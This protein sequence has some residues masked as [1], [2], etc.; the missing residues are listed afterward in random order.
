MSLHYN[1]PNSYLFVDGTEIHKFTAIDYEIVPNNL[2]LENVSKDFSTSNIEK[3]GLNG[4]IYDLSV[5]YDSIDVSDIKDIHSYLM[6]N[7]IV[8]KCYDL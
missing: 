3:T 6:K 8:S 2:Y 4:G 1:G 5:D 7:G